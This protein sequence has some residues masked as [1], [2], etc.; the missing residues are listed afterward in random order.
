M[1]GDEIEEMFN[2]FARYQEGS[3]SALRETEVELEGDD[4]EV[5][6]PRRGTRL[7]S[8]IVYG[9]CTDDERTVDE[10]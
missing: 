3:A 5:M 1:I 6:I 2:K 9:R 10:P 8:E 4:L 7:P